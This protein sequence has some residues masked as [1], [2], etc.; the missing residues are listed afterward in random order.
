[1]LTR[2]QAFALP[3]VAA[4]APVAVARAAPSCLLMP[5]SVEGPYYLDAKQVR[6]DITENRPGI[7]LAL[8]LRVLGT[9]CAP[10]AGARVDVWH[11]DAQGIYS[12]FGEGAGQ[13][14]LRGTQATDANGDVAFTTLYPGWYRGRTT[15]IHYKVFLDTR[16]VLTGQIFFPDALN[17]FIYGNADAY[18]RGDERDTL[19]RTDGIA[20]AA[21]DA[22]QAA[23]REERARYVASLVVGVDPAAT[24]MTAGPGGPPGGPFPGGPPPGPPPNESGPP[25]GPP[26]EGG[27]LGPRIVQLTPQ[28]RLEALFPAPARE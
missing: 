7:P 12:G 20:L 17:E 28:E 13:A 18:R 15:H 1:M 23:I 9:D 14:F 22:A 21:T 26:P 19:N 4:L 6:A 25:P 3:A 11:C 24:G 5:Q 27:P 2:R 16:T 10:F 8:Q